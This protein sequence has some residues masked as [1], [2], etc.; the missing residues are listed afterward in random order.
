MPN[1]AEGVADTG[2]SLGVDR[3]REEGDGH[4]ARLSRA[5]RWELAE[6]LAQLGSQGAPAG[7]ADHQGRG[8]QRLSGTAS[9]RKRA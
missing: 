8:R 9:A 3:S 4:A 2:S 1:S 6:R 5:L 7:A